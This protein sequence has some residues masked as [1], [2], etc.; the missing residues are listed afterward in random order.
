MYDVF[1]YH[2][3]FLLLN[4]A[5]WRAWRVTS[6]GEVMKTAFGG[7]PTEPM[8]GDILLGAGYRHGSLF[9]P[10]TNQIHGHA[11]GPPGAS[12]S[13]VDGHGVWWA[14]G[15]P[16]NG[17]TV[18]YSAVPGESWSKHLIGEYSDPPIGCV[19]DPYFGPF[20]RGSVIVVNGLDLSHVSLDYGRTWRT[21]ELDKML[22]F[23]QAQERNRQ[24]QVASLRDGRLIIGYFQFGVAR[25][26]TN[27][28]FVQYSDYAGVPRRLLWQA[29]LTDELM[30]R[31]GQASPDGGHT[32]LP[33]R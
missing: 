31:P 26:A 25:D 5:Y 24:P 7:G 21:W 22:P 18:V 30:Y 32:W 10:S 8:P 2:G 3:G 9:R 28:S 27:Q 4:Y 17:Q 16:Q 6:A 20:G 12:I 15:Q 33:Y 23:R 11:I 29:G 13:H 1:A 14:R 19:C